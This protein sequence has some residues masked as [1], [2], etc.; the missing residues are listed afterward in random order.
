VGWIEAVF[1]KG[2]DGDHDFGYCCDAAGFIEGRR[3]ILYGK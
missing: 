2:E 3:L 1:N